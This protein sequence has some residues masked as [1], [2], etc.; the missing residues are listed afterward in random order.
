MTSPMVKRQQSNQDILTRNFYSDNGKPQT[1][2]LT[3]DS[4][5]GVVKH[6]DAEY[7]EAIDFARENSVK[8]PM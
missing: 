1:R 5:M 7:N 8:V 3:A 4:G 2:V 6:V